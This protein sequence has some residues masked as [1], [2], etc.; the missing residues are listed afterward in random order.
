MDSYEQQQPDMPGTVLG[1]DGKLY[2]EG[3]P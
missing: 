3:Q 1:E 2:Q